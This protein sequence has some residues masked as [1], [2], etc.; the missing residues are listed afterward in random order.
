MVC[1]ASISEIGPHN[2]GAPPCNSSFERWANFADI[3]WY[4]DAMAAHAAA[5][6][7]V[8]NRQ[9]LV[10]AVRPTEYL[11]QPAH[12][13]NLRK[14][15]CHNFG[16]ANGQDYGLLD[17][18]THMPTPDY[19]LA[20]LWGRLMGNKVLTVAR[21]GNAT[22]RSYAHCDPQ[23][24]GGATVL[25][26]NIGMEDAQIAVTGLRLEHLVL[27]FS[28]SSAVQP[29]HRSATKS[30]NLMHNLLSAQRRGRGIS[31]D[32]HCPW[33][34]ADNAER[35]LDTTTIYYAIP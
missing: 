30:E 10:G 23:G 1:V 25:I 22:I 9:D 17:C 27:L 11:L 12:R 21:G 35:R 33:L 18:A 31:A 20:L 13:F 7:K 29:R 24:L 3:F 4:A 5:G 14:C 6:V 8:F 32:W 26:V 28:V 2:G 34:T 19:F 15:Y 16:R